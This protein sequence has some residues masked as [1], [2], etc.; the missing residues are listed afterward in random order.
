MFHGISEY[1]HVQYSIGAKQSILLSSLHR[2]RKHREADV[3]VVVKQ[4][5]SKGNN[6]LNFFYEKLQTRF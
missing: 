4:V 6:M 3:L 1:L 5:K 2:E